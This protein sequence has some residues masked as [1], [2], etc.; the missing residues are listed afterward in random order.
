MSESKIVVEV[1]TIR[2]WFVRDN[3]GTIITRVTYNPAED[4]YDR[5]KTV[6]EPC[7][8]SVDE[9]TDYIAALANIRDFIK[10]DSK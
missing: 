2:V 8:L 1:E 7:D 4:D 3:E 9:F 6:G 5:I 10:G